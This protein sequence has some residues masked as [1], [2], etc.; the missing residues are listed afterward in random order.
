MPER[1]VNPMHED[2]HELSPSCSI[3]PAD[4]EAVRVAVGGVLFNV[5]N[6]P[7]AVQTRLLG[8]DLAPLR[9][10]ITAAILTAG[11]RLPVEEA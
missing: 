10:R 5:S 2:P 11:L 1:C 3:S 6:F 7:E 8:Q 9:G 4:V